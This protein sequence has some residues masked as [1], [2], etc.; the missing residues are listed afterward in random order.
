MIQQDGTIVADAEDSLSLPALR[1]WLRLWEEA[2]R[3]A[4]TAYRPAL[5]PTDLGWNLR[6]SL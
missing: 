4:P 1:E 2:G 6:L 5:V 3:P